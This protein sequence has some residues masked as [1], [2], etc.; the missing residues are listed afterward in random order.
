MTDFLKKHEWMDLDNRVKNRPLREPAVIQDLELAMRLVLLMLLLL[1]LQ[2]VYY[3]C[4]AG[5]ASAAAASAA[6]AAA[7]GAAADVAESS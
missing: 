1:P 6:P 3:C 7:T 2:V 5:A 4:S